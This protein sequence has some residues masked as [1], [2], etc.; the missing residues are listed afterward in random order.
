MPAA[1]LYSRPLVA[2]SESENL[3]LLFPFFKKTFHGNEF[4]SSES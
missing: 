2:S 3:F 4:A 1:F